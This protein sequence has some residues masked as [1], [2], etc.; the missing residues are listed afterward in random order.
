M[1]EETELRL[2]GEIGPSFFGMIDDVSVIRAL[3]ELRDSRKIHVRLNSPGG[4]YFMGVSI[5]NAF[6][7]HPAKILIHVD[8]LA[9]SA[10]AAVATGGD[11]VIMHPGSLMMIHRAW[12]IALGNQEDLAKVAETLG[13]V[14]ASQIDVY[15]QR[16]GLDKA[17]LK[18]MID[19]ETWM[20]GE[21]AVQ[22]GFADETNT[23]PTGAQAKV[24]DGWYARTPKT[25]DRYTLAAS[26]RSIPSLSIAAKANPQ[27]TARK[28]LWES[29]KKSLLV[30]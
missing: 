30:A 13:K 9:A 19:A 16:T 22:L 20:S 27:D 15:H 26:A 4:D 18:A 24:P 29:R 28:A 3:D 8:A 11:R 2:Y 10:A 12:T 5:A 7:R 23:A 17:K 1:A 14:D 25:V 6:R 21:E